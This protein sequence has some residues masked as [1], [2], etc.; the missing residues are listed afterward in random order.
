MTARRVAFLMSD[1][2]GGHRAAADAIRVAMQRRY[3]GEYSFALIDVY[4]RYTP[5]P[6]T[7][8]PE[9]YPRWVNHAE[10]T[11]SISYKFSTARYQHRLVMAAIHQLWG[12]GVRRMV[13]EH[14]CDVIVS[15]H[16]LFS[17][18]VMRALNT[19]LLHRPPFVTVI[20]D[21]VSTHAFWYEPQVERC[22]TP[23]QAAYDR[24]LKFGMQ[25]DQ[26]RVTGLPVHPEFMDG[27]L[28]KSDARRKLGWDADL[29]AVLL[30]GGGDGMGPVYQIARA[31]ND[32]KLNMQFAIIAGRNKSLQR[33]LEAVDWHQPTVIYPFVNNMPELMAAADV[34]VTKAGPATICEACIAGLPIVLSGAVPG[35]E[36]GNVTYVIENEAGVYAPGAVEV[37]GTLAGWLA[38][39]PDGLAI[40]SQKALAL[41]RPNAV[42]EIADEI[43]TQ[44]QRGPI[45]TPLDERD[46]GTQPGLSPAPED[47]WVF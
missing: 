27:L 9:V 36:D 17:R 23:T 33:R 1:T 21:L 20:T 39:G 41:G 35:Q 12:R 29:P 14:P 46:A 4:R 43:H 13:A 32:R 26:M 34:L 11:W 31:I 6:F 22:L 40:R 2:G 28:E 47:G 42:W 7:Y 45:R 18:P 15:V 30:I 19:E 5:F 24:G 16:S 37:A 10:M 8:M 38:E 44:A 3:P 25:P